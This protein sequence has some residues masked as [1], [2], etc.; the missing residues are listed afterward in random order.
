MFEEGHEG[1]DTSPWQ[2]KELSEQHKQN[3]SQGLKGLTRSDEYIEENLLGENHWNW[4]GG[5]SYEEYPTDFNPKLKR[6]IRRRNCF[7]CK[8]CGKPQEDNIDE[9]GKKLEVH[10]LDEDKNNTGE[11]NLVALCT[12]CH[13]RHHN[14]DNFRID[15]L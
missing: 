4:Q 12:K 9:F 10:H 7:R 15:N 14:S 13:S 6:G 3:I 11:D 1:Y 2:G 8:N 5:R